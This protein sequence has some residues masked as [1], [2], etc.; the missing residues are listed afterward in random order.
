L[1]DFQY[2]GKLLKILGTVITEEQAYKARSYKEFKPK[3]SDS[4]PV[5]GT[6]DGPLGLLY[7]N[8]TDIISKYKLD[9][10]Q[11]YC[12]FFSVEM[13]NTIQTNLRGVGL[14]VSVFGEQGREEINSVIPE[15]V[16]KNG[17]LTNNEY[18]GIL[19]YTFQ[20]M[21]SYNSKY[22]FIWMLKKK[23]LIF[24]LIWNIWNK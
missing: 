12:L 18:F 10:N 2:N 19:K 24:Q 4:N 1:A 8:Q 22:L 21:I 9:P 16:Y 6:A 5:Y 7:L 3:E 14:E 13:L 15:N 17:K 23:W 20:I 11:N